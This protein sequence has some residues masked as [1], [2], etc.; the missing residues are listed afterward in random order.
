MSLVYWSP[1][2]DGT[3]KNQGMINIQAAQSENSHYSSAT[4]G[5]LGKCIKTSSSSSIDTSFLSDWVGQNS[6]TLTGWFYFPLSEIKTIVDASSN[7]SSG[8]PIP[9]GN[10][11]GYCSYAGIT[12]M[13]YSDKPFTK[14]IVCMTVRTGNALHVA[15]CNFTANNLMDKWVHI[16]GI[17]DNVNLKIGLYVNGEQVSLVNITS[18]TFSSLHLYINKNAVYGGNGPGCYIPFYCND[19][20]VYKD[21]IL[22]DK[23]IEHL[24]EGLFLHY[25]LSDRYNSSNLIYNGYGEYGSDGWSGATVSTSD[26]PSDSSVKAVFT[27]G[28]TTEKIP[29]NAKDNMFTVSCYIKSG[30]GTSGYVYPSILP[31]D[32]DNKFISNVNCMDGFST[33][34]QT[35]L[36]QPL[37]KGDTVVYCSDLSAWNTA[38]NNYYYFLAI[39]GYKD[40]LGNVYPD[41]T[42]TADVPT[43][44]TYSD[45]SRINKTNNTITLLSAYTGEPRPAGTKVCQATA[46]STYYYPFGGIDLS[47]IQS[48]TYKTATFYF[49]DRNRLRYAKYIQWYNYPGAKYA[50]VKI[51][52]D[53]WKTTTVFDVS[54]NQHNGVQNNIAFNSNSPVNN[55]CY[56]FSGSNSSIRTTANT[57]HIGTGDFTISA[58]IYIESSNKS[59]QPVISNKTTAANS[60]GCAIYYNHNQNKFLWS[61]ADGS[62]STEIWT[63]NTFTNIYNKWIHIVMVRNSSDAKKGYFYIDGVRQELASVPA[64]RNISTT[65]ELVIG[66]LYSDHA[67]YRWTGKISDVRMYSTA[68]DE[69]A[70]K[71]LYNMGGDAS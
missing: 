8:S 19:L 45:K 43:F 69:D 39:F 37:K 4:N 22:T 64:I 5:K 38:T 52:D 67:D 60:V 71:K 47:S 59:Y 51:T 3:V 18:Q 12:L 21:E 32:I 68:L 55:G 49:K 33:T 29:I 61:T 25:P 14:F 35:T 57:Q 13:W 40:S 7:P 41:F 56:I 9:T 53:S 58:W 16:A 10:L 23:Q 30:G 2:T 6:N 17:W 26:L 63:S 31:Y 42:Y 28:T 34:W 15:N 70:I 11:L 27:N 1:M 66:A 48:W 50:G 44:G 54:G 65:H 62:N 46:G 24:A 36:A 20:R